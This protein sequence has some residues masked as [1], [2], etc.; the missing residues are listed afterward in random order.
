MS[1]NRPLQF[2]QEQLEIINANDKT[3]NVVAAAGAGKTRVLV[4]RYLRHVQKDLLSPDQILTITFTKKA[5]AE[6]KQRIVTS[7]REAELFDMAQIAETGPIQT[8]HSFCE[9][10]LRENSLEA[11]LDPN[12]EILG[13]SKTRQLALQSIRE[14]LANSDD[15]STAAEGVISELAGKHTRG[16]RRSPYALLEDSIYTVLMQLRSSGKSREQI[17]IWHQNPSALRARWDEVITSAIKPKVIEELRRSPETD[18]IKQMK[19]AHKSVG[20][21]IP[22]WLSPAFDDETNEE[23][24]YQSLGLVQL[25][26]EAWWRFDQHQFELQ[27]LDFSELESRAVRLMERSEVT[28]NRIREQ[29]KVLMIDEAQDV[30]PVQYQLLDRLGIDNQMR[31]GDRQQSIYGFRQ[32]D[33]KLFSQRI[34]TE[35]A[36]KLT[37]NYRSDEGILLFIDDLFGKI[38]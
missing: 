8:I 33:V 12:F 14:A 30:N 19:A 4:Q 10:L 13:D 21:K 3:L 28:R 34:E 22:A 35:G 36:R 15:L 2:S 7:L 37:K 23:A 27:A 6:M 38:W 5:A 18:W 17:G 11:G 9:R 1:T 24:L 25:A 16:L 26:I 32:A 20:E 31:V 29:Y